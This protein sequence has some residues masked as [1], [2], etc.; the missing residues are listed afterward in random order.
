MKNTILMS[1]ADKLPSTGEVVLRNKLDGVS[2]ET[3]NKIS[4]SIP[5][6]NLKSP[7][8]GLVLGLLFG[9]LGVD[10]FYKGDIGLGF[11]KLLLL[12]ILGFILNLAQ[13][14]PSDTTYTML[15]LFTVVA[16][17]WMFVD[18]FLVFSGIKKDNLNKIL[19]IL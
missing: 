13:T 10:R 12:F 9:G 6:L 1:L 14:Q 15:V 11:M 3:L 16:V 2:D 19:M 17:I 4:A 5:M 18:L 8:A 7:G